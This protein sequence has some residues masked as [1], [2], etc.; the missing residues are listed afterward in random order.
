LDYGANANIPKKEF[1]G[2][3]LLG[4]YDYKTGT[5]SLSL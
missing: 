1:R 5:S 3:L 2:F 4:V